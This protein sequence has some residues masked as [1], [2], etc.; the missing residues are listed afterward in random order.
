MIYI[1]VKLNIFTSYFYFK[2]SHV[3]GRNHMDTVV[4]L[5]IQAALCLFAYAWLYVYMSL[6]IISDTTSVERM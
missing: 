6:V 1:H 2:S 4:T 3:F 5:E